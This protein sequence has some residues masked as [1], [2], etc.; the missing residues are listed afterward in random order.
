MDIKPSN[1]LVSIN[2]NEVI[3]NKYDMKLSDFGASR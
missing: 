2:N 1:I 3:E